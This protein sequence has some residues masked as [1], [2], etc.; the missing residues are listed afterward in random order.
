MTFQFRRA[1]EADRTYLQRL[2]YLTEVFG[3]E[4]APM[5]EQHRDSIVSGVDDYVYGWDPDSDGGIIATDEFHTPAGGLWF[6][7]WDAPS[8][9]HA[10]LGPDIPE[11]AIAI[12]GRFAG[13][14]LGALLLEQAVQ[15]GREQGAERLALWV[16]PDNPRARHRYEQFG[17]DDVKGLDNVMALDL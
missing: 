16:D 8:K 14:R 15:L 11:L 3:D 9:G 12:E 17:F 7:Y 2:N 13:Q 10:N 4:D 6:R 1:V 5:H